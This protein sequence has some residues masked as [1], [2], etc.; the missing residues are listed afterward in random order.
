MTRVFADAVYWVAVANRKDQWY[1]KV[2]GVMRS[3]GPVTLVTTEEVMDEFL[4]HYSGHGPVLR[5]LAVAVVERAMASPRV[6]VRPQTHQS[7]LEGLAFY[8]ARPDK[9]YSLTDCISMETM[10]QEGLAAV[11]THDH[12]FK[13]EGF[14]TLFSMALHDSGRGTR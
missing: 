10:R 12:H 13:Q 11:P 8:K 2:A 9:G 1:A 6:V 14:T 3:L 7:F 5:N 4:A